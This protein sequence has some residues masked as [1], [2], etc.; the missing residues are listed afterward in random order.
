M[1]NFIGAAASNQG[2]LFLNVI[3]IRIAPAWWRYET[4]VE[5]ARSDTTGAD[6]VASYATPFWPGAGFVGDSGDVP[7]QAEYSQWAPY[8]P[9]SGDS[10]RFGFVGVTRDQYGSPIG[11]CTVKLF[12]TSDDL[13]LDSTTSDP[14]GNFLLN[15]AYYPDAHYIVARKSG[16]PDVDGVTNN[17]LVGS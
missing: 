13:L 5:I 15:T 1:S 4:S 16:S 11:G 6:A 2:H 3:D 9:V 12:R 17:N 8:E 7:V 14:S 10:S